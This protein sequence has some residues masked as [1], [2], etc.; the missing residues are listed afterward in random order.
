MKNK[1]SLMIF[2]IFFSFFSQ[3]TMPVQ[4]DSLVEDKDE[5]EVFP[6]LNYDSDVGVGYGAKAFFYNLFSGKES[7]DLIL[8]NSSK[9]ER[10]YRLAFSLTDKQRR[11]GKKYT[12]AFDF[13][14]DYDKWIN[15]KY[16][17]KELNYETGVFEEKDFNYTRKDIELSAIFSRGFL[18]DLIAELGLKYKNINSTEFEP[19]SDFINY[20]NYN[21]NVQNV[22]L[23]YNIRW[24]TRKDYINPQ[25]AV[26]LEIDNEI[27]QDIITPPKDNYYKFTI[28]FQSYIKIFEPSYIFAGRLIY[29]AIYNV[30]DQLLIPLGGNNTLR[31]LPQSRYL[32]SSAVII[33][34][35]FRFPIWW[36]IGGV[37]AVDLGNALELEEWII[38]PVAGLRFFMDNFVVRF[39]AG[40]G[41]EST[42][43]YFNFGHMF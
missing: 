11:Q 14:A 34:N 33:N 40:F 35:E 21:S 24:D 10:W 25:N 16:Y 27:G 42:C 1:K 7:F 15:Y 32:S 37:A 8:Y 31:G 20:T 23:F 18:K 28:L 41:K 6:I 19:P 17:Y 36:R 9:G 39:D 38:N 2:S 3:L 30:S 29:Q 4:L 43:I 12:L 5:W 26:V 22:S 13:I